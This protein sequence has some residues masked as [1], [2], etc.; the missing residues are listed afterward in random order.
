[1]PW[2]TKVSAADGELI[3]GARAHDLARPQLKG[4]GLGVDAR[5]AEADYRIR[6]TG[7]HPHGDRLAPAG[8][9]TAFSNA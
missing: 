9:Y 6:T 3:V 1:L 7:D 8:V 4:C 5:I 2:I